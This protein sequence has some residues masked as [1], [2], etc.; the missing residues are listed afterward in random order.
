MHAI[1]MDMLK[2]NPNERISS[3]DVVSRIKFFTIQ[4]NHYDNRVE[5]KKI[6]RS[7][8]EAY[9]KSFKKVKQEMIKSTEERKNSVPFYY[10]EDK[11][12]AEIHATVAELN[13]A[14]DVVVNKKGQ[15]KWQLQFQNMWDRNKNDQ[16]FNWRLKLK[17]A[18][19]RL[20]NYENRVEEYKKKMRQEINEFFKNSKVTDWKE[21][22]KNKKF[23]EMFK[24]YLDEAK[25]EFPTPDVLGEL[26]KVCHNS[27]VIK[28]KI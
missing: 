17:N 4:K 1:I 19:D 21:S 12:R 9:E 7:L 3:A 2:A 16:D 11:H 26:K 22:E 15:E 18:Y 13:T 28:K 5:Y 6:E 27:S 20:F 14:V 25:K 23:E 8:T 10:F 24:R